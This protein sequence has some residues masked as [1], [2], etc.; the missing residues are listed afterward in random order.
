[1]N[2]IN[3]FVIE[4]EFLA[5][6]ALLWRVQTQ[7]EHLQNWLSPAGFH[8]IHAEM[9]FREGGR[10]FYGIQGP[11]GLQM[12]ALQQFVEI[13]PEKRIVHLQS[14]SDKE[15]ALSR[16]PMAPS[17]P[18]YM[19][20]TATYEDTTSGTTTYTIS[21]KPHESDALGISTFDGARV[22]MQAGFEG[23]FVKLDAY[24]HELQRK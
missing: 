19:H 13:V 1:M 20:V 10:Y 14:F 5:P 3:P 12:W 17:W 6:R 11:N 23:T 18:S 15:G 22:G 16:H 9:D 8:S 24:L 7:A 4:R 21:W 2:I